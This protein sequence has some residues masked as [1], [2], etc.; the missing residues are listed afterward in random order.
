MSQKYELTYLPAK[1][2]ANLIRL[3][4]AD[5]G[6]PYKYTEYDR[7]NWPAAKPN[8]PFKQLPVLTVDGSIQI[9]QSHS[10]AR[11]L[12]REHGLMG[13]NSIEQAQVDMWLDQTLDLR[14]RL[15][16]VVHID[17]EKLLQPFLNSLPDMLEIFETRLA[18]QPASA[19]HLALG[20]LTI[21]DYALFDVLYYLQLLRPESLDNTPVLKAFYTEF[22]ARPKLRA[23]METDEFK[24]LRA[25]GSPH[26]Q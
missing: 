4:L 25:T 12:A 10:I 14:N 11:Y 9:A 26:L 13:S 2:K 8:Y 18:A 5:Q 15:L 17:F 24:C 3:M 1:G 6:I 20:K 7:A 19:K 23:Y 16:N 22:A 21:A